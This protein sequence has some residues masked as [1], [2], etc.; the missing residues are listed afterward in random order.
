MAAQAATSRGALEELY[1]A[2]RPRV[3]ALCVHIAGAM[4]DGEDATQETFFLAQRA[5]STF[6]GESSLLTWVLRIAV[7][8]SLETRARRAKSRTVEIPED[9]PSSADTY[10]IVAAREEMR[11]F[12]AALDSLPVEQRAVL[13]LAAVDGL[14]HAEIACVLGIAE[15]T[16]WS[17]LARAR[18]RLGELLA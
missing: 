3:V 2:E 1:R 9:L 4:Q 13:G 14:S 15:G 17:R 11:R 12:L 6:R 16:V 18:A 10:A 5:L 7:R 8:V